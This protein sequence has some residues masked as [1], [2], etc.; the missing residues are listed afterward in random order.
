MLERDN[1]GVKFFTP[2]MKLDA[3]EPSLS[4]RGVWIEIP[5]RL[6][7]MAKKN[8]NSKASGVAVIYARYS[9]HAQREA[10]IEQQIHECTQYAQRNGLKIASVYS[11][12]AISGKTDLRPQ[13]QK[14]MNDAATGSFRCVI[15]WK[16]NRMGRNMMQAMVNEARL[17][18]LGV[19]CLYVEEDF[20]DTAAGRFALRNMMN[21]NQFYSDNLAEDVMRG[22]MDNAAKCKVNGPCSI[23]LKRGEDG[24][25]AID[26]TGAEVVRE[27]FERVNNGDSFVDIANDLNARRIKTAR[28]NRWN[29][30]SFHRLIS[31]EQY[32]GIYS[33]AG[34]RIENGIPPILRK[35]LFYSVQEKLKNQKRVRGRHTTNE[36]YLLTGKLFCGKCGSPMVGCSG[37]GKS[38]AKYF[39]Y[40]CQKKRVEKAC[41][42]KNVAKDFIEEKVTTAVREYLL[43]DDVI[44]WIAD[45][46]RAFL[47]AHRRD[48]ALISM[49]AELA[50][51][52]KSIK[53]IVTAIEQGVFTS[54]TRERLLE[55]ENERQSLRASIAVTEATL[56]DVPREK[57]E[58]WL[59]SFR[60]GDAKSR[61]YQ[62]KLIDNFVQAV[63]LYDDSIRIV[64]NYTGKNN[65]INVSL[66]DTD[67]AIRGEMDAC[68]LNLSCGVPQ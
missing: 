4:I 58:Y 12:R 62:A 59:Q 33:F 57:I 17:N 50:V 28:G 2:G 54:S 32:I 51:V 66:S 61:A 52:D 60:S 35:E 6:G 56:E 41:D 67:V 42:K 22:M 25:Y 24:R 26:E 38:G 43:D 45:G 55:L 47:D 48:S 1:Y 14:M 36:D 18:D 44:T 7:E 3:D 29:K 27:I 64:C 13:F 11:D 23:G 16:S 53:N 20:D 9:S 15:A 21:V 31:N 37:T 19:R 34:L 68:L 39:Y 63:Y 10:S 30:N 40:A 8:E 46:Y 49:Q 65:A 5:E